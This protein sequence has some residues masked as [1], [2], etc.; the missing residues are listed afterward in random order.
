MP[1][2][3]FRTLIVAALALAASATLCSAQTSTPEQ[4]A[5]FEQKIRPVLV[6]S[7]YQC[8]SAQAKL[9]K[10]LKGSLYL[11]TRDAVLKGG[12]TGPAIVPGQSVKSL[13][14]KA[15][16]WEDADIEMPPKK[17][18][19]DS[20]VADF[21]K[22]IDMGA[23]D[24]R[25]GGTAASAR[26]IDIAAGREHWAYRPLA[27]AAPPAVKNTAWA[28]TEIDRFILAKIEAVGIAP[29]APVSREKLARRAYFD[30]L[31]LPPAP[32]QL[33]AFLKDTA[34]DAYE[35]LIDRLLAS[36]QYGERWGRHWL[37]VVRFAESGGYEFDKFR[38]G[39][40]H[41]RDWVIRAFNADMPYD[42][43]VRMQL[44]GDKLMPNSLEGASATGFLVAGPYPGQ[45]TAKTRERIRYDQ[46][47]DMVSVMGESLLGATLGCVRCHDHKYDPFPQQDYY[48]IAAALARTEHGDIKIDLAFA[49]TQKKVAE[50]EATLKPMR[51]AVAAYA[52]DELPER[53]ET[54]QREKLPELRRDAVAAWQAF[55]V[56][57]AVGATAQLSIAPGGIVRYEG[58]KAKDDTYTIK[59]VTFQ[60]GLKELRLDALADK[61]SPAGGPGLSTNGNFVLADIKVIAKPLDP[62]NKTKP[63]TLKLTPV[64]ATFEQK[65]YPLSAAVD[66]SP[67]SG[68]AVAPK[69]GVD[70]AAVFAIQDKT[71]G[72]AGGTEIEIQLKFSRFY[73]LGKL[74]IS[75]SNGE[76]P[77]EIDGP[78]EMQNSRELLAL[79]EAANAAKPAVPLAKVEG[80]AKA[81]LMRWFAAV[82]ERA[83]TLLAALAA[84]ERKRPKP[85]LIEVYST[86]AG[87]E[88][89]YLLK[90]GEVDN[91]AGK[92]PV[93]FIQVL[94]T[95]EPSKWIASTGAPVIT[96][97][98]P[99]A[100]P[101]PPAKKARVAA[102]PPPPPATG[103]DSRIALANWMTDHDAGAGDLLARVI[104]NRMWKY[105]LGQ[106]L[107]HSP[108]DF[109]AQGERP[110]HPELLDYLA[111]E[112][113]RNNWRLKPI[114]RLI[115]TSAVYQ[116]GM[117]ANP[118]ARER[119]PENKLW[120]HRPTHRLEA[121]AI[122]DSLLLAGG[123]LD[124]KMYG[125]SE[126]TVDS[127]RRSVY[128]RVKRSELIPFLTLFDGPEPTQSVGDRGLTTVPTQALTLLNSPFVRD[129]SA[130]LAKRALASAASPDAALDQAF[131]IAV[132]RM[133]TQHERAKFT[134]YLNAEVE[135]LQAADK[136]ITS[137][138]AMEKAFTQTCL[139]ILCSNEFIYVD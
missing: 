43:F 42:Q 29:S 8:H 1:K 119:D 71:A 126:T 116:Q 32:E 106:G 122:R 133:P 98:V 64:K 93:A 97:P 15:I 129:A 83:G 102:P 139:V 39:A 84:Q 24:P 132:A 63:V 74:R 85:D 99:V 117:D 12:D 16:R 82:D 27:K 59:A 10:K 68:W 88:E 91:K 7:C 110:T 2:S 40:F 47:D 46:L 23:P 34:P 111:S 55:D 112:L 105:H 25:T 79:V 109:G 65:D 123:R 66:N 28:R 26:V 72:F 31:G 33:D 90:R 51:D 52:K 14:M 86:K 62:A 81:H 103:T 135:R 75:F 21:A 73:G 58:N 124:E 41:Y 61:A 137:A 22:W 95:G 17:R 18:L 6:E 20:V 44:A 108:N 92:A 36:P 138:L 11:D 80:A 13:L 49:E 118:I 114:H 54:W 45:I 38:P 4:I 115:M 76:K 70:H 104:V 100:A 113:I 69:M 53:L 57:S 125:P 87:G 48:G 5:F 127:P 60:T 121:E 56:V 128:L 35:K 107:V 130:R 9:D 89:V 131:R 67:Q 78:V 30:L 134:S 101:A 50:F 136:K 94:T 3:C 77:L 37:D 96:A 120:W 19:P